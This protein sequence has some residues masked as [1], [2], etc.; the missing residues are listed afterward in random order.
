[1]CDEVSRVVKHPSDEVL[2]RYLLGTLEE[3]EKAE[4]EH[5]LD[6]CDECEF[7]CSEVG[8]VFFNLPKEVRETILQ[9]RA[10]ERAVADD[11]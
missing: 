2:E 8:R 10:D 5:H 3:S 4:V 9:I 11:Y 7:A 1:M 6:R